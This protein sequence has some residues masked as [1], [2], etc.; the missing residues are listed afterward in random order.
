M[1][2]SPSRQTPYINPLRSAIES[3]WIEGYKDALT[4][5]YEATLIE[6]YRLSGRRER[7]ILW[8]KYRNMRRL[9]DEFEKT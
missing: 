6:E 1:A 3:D 8:I 7:E 2:G 4:E 9:F 5:K